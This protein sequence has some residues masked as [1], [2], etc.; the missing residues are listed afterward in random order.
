MGKFFQTIMIS[1]CQPFV[2]LNLSA[3][4]S[5]ISRSNEYI[6]VSPADLCQD[7]PAQAVFQGIQEP[8]QPQGRLS[9]PM[10]H[11][12][13][14]DLEGE[15]FLFPLAPAVA[16]HALDHLSSPLFSSWQ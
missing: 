9:V 7:L 16:G 8:R 10:V 3:F 14:L 2:N 4:R 5:R 6:D 1:F 15:I 11:G 13:D 12:L